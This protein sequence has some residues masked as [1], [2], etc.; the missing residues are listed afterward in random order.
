MNPRIPDVSR[1]DV[2]RIIR[3]DYPETQVEGIVEMLNRLSFGS[4]PLN[5]HRIR[6]AVLKL[7]NGNREEIRR[8]IQVA[9]TDFRD[10][11]T[12]AE[13]PNYSQDVIPGVRLP[14]KRLEQICE[15]DWQQYQDWL[16]RE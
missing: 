11:L 15:Q 10:V 5:V 2:E 13:H 3:R 14:Q 6:L 16:K 1:S 7:A 4:I 8:Y 12:L 9:L